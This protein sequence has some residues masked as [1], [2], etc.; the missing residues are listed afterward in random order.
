MIAGKDK[1]FAMVIHGG[2]RG[3][4]QGIL[5]KGIEIAQRKGVEKILVELGPC[6][7]QQAF[8]VGPEVVDSLFQP[9]LT[10]NQ[11]QKNICLLK[12]VQDRWHID[13]QAFALSQLKN[14][15][16]PSHQISVYRSCT[17]GNSDLWPSYRR[18]G[19]KAKRLWSSI[20]I[21]SF[22]NKNK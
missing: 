12:G 1:P 15:G 8:E 7:S 5:L 16:I 14:L 13:L 21:K 11:D 10:L 18:D 17:F 2:W 20:Q 9:D 6:I 4:A 19:Q 22:S 3:L